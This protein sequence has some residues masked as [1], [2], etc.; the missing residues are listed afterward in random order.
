MGTQHLQHMIRIGSDRANHL[1]AAPAIP[2]KSSIVVF[3]F[4]TFLHHYEMC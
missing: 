2:Y 4:L 3:G 1:F